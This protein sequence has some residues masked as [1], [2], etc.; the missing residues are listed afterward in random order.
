MNQRETPLR[1]RRRPSPLL[2]LLLGL[3][4]PGLHPAVARAAEGTEAVASGDCSSVPS[5]GCEEAP[6]PAQPPLDTGVRRPLPDYDGR[7]APP[8]PAARAALWLPRVVL[9]PLYA[10]S[11]F[12]VRQPLGYVVTQAEEHGLPTLIV[13]ALTFGPRR[14]AGIVP[15]ALIDFGFRPSVGVLVFV[16]DAYVKHND[17]R[18]RAAWGGADWRSFGFWDFFELTGDSAV[19]VRAGHTVRPDRI[20]NGLGPSA[21]GGN[22]RYSERRSD[23]ALE[24]RLRLWRSSTLN[25]VVGLR[26]SAFDAD[27]ACCEDPSVSHEVAQGRFPLPEAMRDGYTLFRSGVDLALDSRARRHLQEPREGSDFVEPAGTGVRV[28]GRFSQAGGAQRD[29][30]SSTAGTSTYSFVRYGGT[31]GAFV[32][33]TGQQRVV[34]L[35]IGA[36]FAEPLA[37]EGR[38]PFTE[39]VDLGGRRPLRGFLEGALRDRSAVVGVVEYQWPVWVWL[40]GKIQYEVGNVFGTQLQGFELGQL[41]QSFGLGLAANNARDHAFELY[42]GAGSRPFDEGAQIDSVR[43]LVGASSGF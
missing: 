31:V 40:D 25:A 22:A 37:Q 15:T 26:D 3:A 38:I 16:N 5:A 1:A 21:W 10:V 34:G 20:F 32:D 24:Y 36:D 30:G 29:G 33:L 9:S 27:V 7:G 41:R 13:D 2:A 35:S 17:L 23:A 43:I 8:T 6:L 14:N 28:A 18:L 4:G 11:E 42:A 19:G 12:V 39:L